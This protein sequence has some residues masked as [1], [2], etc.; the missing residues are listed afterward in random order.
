MDAVAESA[1]HP[2]RAVEHRARPCSGGRVG[3]GAGGA[4]SR[5]SAREARTPRWRRHVGAVG[6]SDPDSATRPPRRRRQDAAAR[7][8][9]R[10]ALAVPGRPV[11][12]AHALLAT[13]SIAASRRSRPI[14][15]GA[16]ASARAPRPAPPAE[17]ARRRVALRRVLGHRA[18]NDVVERRRHVRRDLDAPTA[19]AHT[20]EP[21]ASPGRSPA[22]TG[23]GRSRPRTGRNQASR[24]RC[25][26]RHGRAFDLLRRRVVDRAHPLARPRQ[27]ADRAGVLREAEVRQVDVV[28]AGDQDV[29]RLDVAMDQVPLVGGVEGARDLGD[30]AGGTRGLERRRDRSCRAGSSPPPSASR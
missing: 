7:D 9:A 28:L 27:P 30:E 24:R 22:C 26:G 14:C 15:S 17:L 18:L 5:R 10:P 21:T 29:G 4:T 3:I 6:S 16:G 1:H 13:G 2:D 23:A 25:C 20:C 8:D 11:L 19:A 12:A